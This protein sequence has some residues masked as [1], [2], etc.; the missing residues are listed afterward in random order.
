MYQILPQNI[1]IK[2]LK[3]RG[4]KHPQWPLLGM[5]ELKQK[6]KFL[7]EW[8][9]FVIVINFNYKKMCKNG[10]TIKKTILR[11]LV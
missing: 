2:C 3:S 7:R 9:S 10:W 5:A 1:I 8:Q 11:R 4:Q 6:L